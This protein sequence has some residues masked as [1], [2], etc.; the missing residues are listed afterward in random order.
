M[1]RT[2]NNCCSK[3]SRPNPNRSEV[4]RYFGLL[5]RLQNR[6]IESRAAFEKA[7]A[8]DRYNASAR[9][10]MGW[11]LLFLGEPEAGLAEGEEALRQRPHDPEMRGVYQQQAWCLLLLD[12]VQPAVEML[13]NAIAER[14]RQW[15]NRFAL[16][17]ALGLKGN[18]LSLIHI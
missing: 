6:L 12:R 7:L 4:Y 15:V 9:L 16:A 1:A 14:P 18:L 8:I 3:R 5:L 2:P 10:Q 11:T 17:A 13:T